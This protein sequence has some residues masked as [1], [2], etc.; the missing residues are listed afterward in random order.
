MLLH[1]YFCDVWFLNSNVKSDSK[2]NLKMIW[3]IDLKKEKL[4]LS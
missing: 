3:K 1:I 2:G 4:N